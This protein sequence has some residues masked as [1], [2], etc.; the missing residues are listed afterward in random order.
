MFGFSYTFQQRLF[1]KSKIPKSKQKSR[2]YT[3]LMD[4]IHLL[5]NIRWVQRDQL[6]QCQILSPEKGLLNLRRSRFSTHR[7]YK[8]NVYHQPLY[9]GECLENV[10][11]FGKMHPT[12]IYPRFSDVWA[13]SNRKETFPETQDSVQIATNSRQCTCLW[14][15]LFNNILWV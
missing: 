11:K 6:T 10:G 13:F 4:G 14:Y 12:N 1:H 2:E 8:A 7:C 15:N 9:V 5:D 3:V